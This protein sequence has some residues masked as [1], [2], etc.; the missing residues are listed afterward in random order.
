[1]AYRSSSPLLCSLAFPAPSWYLRT[2]WLSA[3]LLVVDCFWTDFWPQACFQGCCAK[4]HLALLVPVALLRAT[5]E[6]PARSSP[7]GV[8]PFSR[9]CIGVRLGGLGSLLAQPALCPKITLE[10]HRSL[11]KNAIG[12]CRS[13][14]HGRRSFAGLDSPGY[15]NGVCD[16]RGS[17]GLGPRNFA[18]NTQFYSDLG[19][20]PISAPYL[21]L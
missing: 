10:R 9:Q 16:G 11:G 15:G 14:V 1:V 5:R 19:S 17:L 3:A 18:C 7:V 2:E 8:G 21:Q 12:L 13:Y 4:P 20:S 6:S